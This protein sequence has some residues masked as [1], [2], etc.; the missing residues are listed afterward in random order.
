LQNLRKK[1]VLKL[2]Q[3]VVEAPIPG[4]ILSVNVAVGT[5]VEEGGVVCMLESMKMENPILSP[6]KGVIQEIR[7]AVGQAVKSGD[8][9]AVIEY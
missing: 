8:V 2:P 3:E 1:G 4:K 5:P 7:V 9:L 6:V